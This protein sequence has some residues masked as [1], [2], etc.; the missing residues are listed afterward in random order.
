MNYEK[1]HKKTHWQNSKG[2]K[3]T[4]FT[5]YLLLPFGRHRRKIG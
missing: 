5:A 2:Y 4:L 3:Q 1:N